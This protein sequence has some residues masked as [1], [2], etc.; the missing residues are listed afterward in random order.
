MLKPTR[1]TI[2]EFIEFQ[3]TCF[4]WSFRPSSGVQD[5]THSISYTS[6]VIQVSSLLASRHEMGRDDKISAIILLVILF[7]WDFKFHFGSV[8]KIINLG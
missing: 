4:G 6:Y 3:S 2:F 5:C 8:F 7:L 1:C